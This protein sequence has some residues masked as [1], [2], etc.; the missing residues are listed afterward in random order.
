M[1]NKQEFVKS[2]EN[3]LK[4]SREFCDLEALEYVKKGHEEYVYII[5]KGFLQKRICVSGDSCLGILIDFV[6]RFNSTPYI[7]DEELKYL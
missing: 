5:Y 1:E 6:N 2:L 3:L 4:L 7:L